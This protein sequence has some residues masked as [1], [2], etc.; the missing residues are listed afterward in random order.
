MEVGIVRGT[1]LGYTQIPG[2]TVQYGEVGGMI[3]GHTIHGAGEVVGETH[4]VLRL[5]G[6]AAGVILTGPD[7]LMDLT[8]AIGPVISRPH[9]TIFITTATILTPITTDVVALQVRQAV[10]AGVLSH[11]ILNKLRPLI[12][13]GIT[14]LLQLLRLLIQEGFSLRDALPI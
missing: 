10:V 13:G 9:G 2:I 14:G 11:Q 6:E 3:L 5:A 1:A 4:I 8:M 12:T 7:T